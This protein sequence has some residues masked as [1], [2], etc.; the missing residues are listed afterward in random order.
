MLLVFGTT[1]SA[2]HVHLDHYPE[3]ETV[4]QLVEE[5]LNC[6]ICGSV[7]HFSPDA[8][9]AVTITLPDHSDTPAHIQP[10]IIE[11]V[12]AHFEGRAP[13]FSISA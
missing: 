8:E 5:E 7:F 10:V 4:H 2:I 1:L 9:Q 3:T 11:P 6:V 13:P 12:E